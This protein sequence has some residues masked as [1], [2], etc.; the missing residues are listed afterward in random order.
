MNLLEFLGKIG[1]HFRISAMMARDSVKSRLELCCFA[2]I[3]PSHESIKLLSREICKEK[4]E[5]N[6][7]LL[8]VVF[9]LD[10]T[11]HRG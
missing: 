4:I 6:A 5:N 10:W 11:R 7:L 9:G 8:I 2:N 3:L 1:R